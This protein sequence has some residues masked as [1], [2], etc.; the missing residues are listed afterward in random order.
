VVDDREYSTSE[1]VIDAK[2]VV[3]KVA[4]LEATLSLELH[5]IRAPLGESCYQVCVSREMI[6]WIRLSQVTYTRCFGDLTDERRGH[7]YHCPP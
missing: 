4:H 7:L 3:A 1:D 2:G 5:L 6:D